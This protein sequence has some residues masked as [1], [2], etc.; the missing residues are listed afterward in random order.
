[1]TR[2][3]KYC[4]QN[5]HRKVF[6][7]TVCRN[8]LRELNRLLS[9]SNNDEVGNFNVI[10]FV[11]KYKSLSFEFVKATLIMY[12]PKLQRQYGYSE[13]SLKKPAV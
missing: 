4:P 6:E 5:F 9:S 10:L 11:M 2:K 13:E 1:M 7:T 3:L 8:M 12:S